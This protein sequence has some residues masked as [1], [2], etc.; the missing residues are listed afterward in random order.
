VVSPI[1]GQVISSKIINTYATGSVD[2]VYFGS[3]FINFVRQNSEVKDVYSTVDVTSNYS[4]SGLFNRVM[5]T[6]NVARAYAYNNL[7]TANAYGLIEVVSS[8]NINDMYFNSDIFSGSDISGTGLTTSEM[9]DENN[10][11]NWDFDEVWFIDEDQ[12]NGFP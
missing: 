8:S 4:A 12:N 6:N 1:A 3:G 10:F 5:N 2:A 7:N 9:Q 11:N